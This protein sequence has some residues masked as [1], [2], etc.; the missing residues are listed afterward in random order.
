MDNP[1]KNLLSMMQDQG[2]KHNPPSICLGEITSINPINIKVEDLIL[3]KDDLLISDNLVQ[4]YKSNVDITSSGTLVSNT[5]NT[6][7]GSGE[8]SFASHSHAINNDY[9][10]TGSAELS[11]KDQL[12]IGDLLA[13]MPTENRQIYIVLCKVV[14]L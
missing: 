14:T 6:S 3:D 2:K 4:G 8:S 13:L 9:N 12:K 5:Q 11:F 7:G 1:Y 10:L